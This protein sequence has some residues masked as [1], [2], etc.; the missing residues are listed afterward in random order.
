MAGDGSSSRL[1][2]P[3][4]PPPYKGRPQKL[5]TWKERYAK[6]DLFDA[7]ALEAANP[8]TFP[9]QLLRN[10]AVAH[11]VA[12]GE[13]VAVIALVREAYAPAVADWAA[14]YLALEGIVTR[15]AT[16]EQFHALAAGH[17]ELTSLRAYLFD[18]SVNLRPAFAL[19][20]PETAAPATDQAL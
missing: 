12:A 3:A 20:P 7:A 1:S 5:A 8:D 2:S 4:R 10:V 16:W 18:K 13:Y 17:D 14:G 15:S 9:E 11:T 19:Q 6:S